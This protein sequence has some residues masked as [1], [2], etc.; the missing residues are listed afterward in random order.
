MSNGCILD[1]MTIKNQFSGID[2]QFLNKYSLLLLQEEADRYM[3]TIK[4][5]ARGTKLHFMIILLLIFLK[6][7]FHISK[8]NICFLRSYSPSYLSKNKF[9]VNI[10]KLK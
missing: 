1:E 9:L 5:Q 2:K 8:L 10:F 6:I 7:I 4:N 3:K